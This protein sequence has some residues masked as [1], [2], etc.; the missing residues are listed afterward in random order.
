MAARYTLAIFTQQRH[1]RLYLAVRQTLQRWMAGQW[2]LG[3][4]PPAAL[5]RTA[6]RQLNRVGEV[7]KFDAVAFTMR[8]LIEGRCNVAIYKHTYIHKNI[9]NM[10]T[11]LSFT[12]CSANW[13]TDAMLSSSLS[14]SS[15]PGWLAVMGEYTTV[16][17]SNRS[18]NPEAAL[19]P[20][21]V[22]K[23]ITYIHTYINLYIHKQHSFKYTG[24]RDNKHHTNTTY[25]TPYRQ[26]RDL[27]RPLLSTSS[28]SWVGEVADTGCPQNKRC[29]S[30]YARTNVC[31]YVCMYVCM[32]VCDTWTWVAPMIQRESN[33]S[34]FSK[35]YNFNTSP[36]P[37]GA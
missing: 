22:Q 17:P 20:E 7:R 37:F 24:G 21:H 13:S 3:S 19:E 12:S 15:I 11:S 30:L 4:T 14:S 16:S 28:Y 33:L 34:K 18:C 10:Y 35:E 2:C 27:P 5:L 29:T 26:Q 25:H 23:T 36:F 32:Y 8:C 9:H 31:T 1:V 6:G